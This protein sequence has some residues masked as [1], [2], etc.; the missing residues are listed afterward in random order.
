MDV[1][2]AG[3]GRWPKIRSIKWKAACVAVMQAAF[4]RLS[5]KPGKSS[6]AQSSQIK[7]RKIR[8][9]FVPGLS[10]DWFSGISS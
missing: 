8:Q 7:Q 6:F 3:G 9:L 2:F 1:P 4:L 5:T 10:H